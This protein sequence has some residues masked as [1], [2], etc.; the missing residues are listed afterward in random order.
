MPLYYVNPLHVLFFFC[1]RKHASFGILISNFA[2]KTAFLR[3]N[4]DS[5]LQT[6]SCLKVSLLSVEAAIFFSVPLGVLAVGYKDSLYRFLHQFLAYIAERWYILRK[7]VVTEKFL[8]YF[9]S[10][11]KEGPIFHENLLLAVQ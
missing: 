6:L 4:S 11:S 5:V 1:P 3:K 9:P 8:R 10:S 2:H 7:G